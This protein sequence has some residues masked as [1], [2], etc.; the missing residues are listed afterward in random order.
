MCRSFQQ[1]SALSNCVEGRVA[2][3]IRLADR[4]V[5]LRLRRDAFLR[6]A[7]TQRTADATKA[8]LADSFRWMRDD[9]LMRKLCD[10][11]RLGDA[12]APEAA[13]KIKRA[14]E[15]GEVVVIPDTPRHSGVG[16]NG[17]NVLKPRPVTF[18]PSQLFRGTRRVSIA[19]SHVR[20]NPLRLSADDGLAI[21]AAR[22]GDVLPDG[23]IATAI[24]PASDCKQLNSD[25]VLERIKKTYEA[26]VNSVDHVMSLDDARPFG[27]ELSS[28][29]DNVLAM[30]A[31]GVSEAQEDD[32]F[33]QYERDMMACDMIGAMYRDPRTYA[34]CTR[35]AFSNYQG[36]RG[37]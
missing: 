26:S 30:A 2:D 22:P 10:L 21:W 6:S 19:G 4:S 27:L 20:P 15:T 34:E 12:D 13:F 32:C 1:T 33:S 36:C 3:E 35:R 16:S 18:T 5:T 11:L 14:F 29:S 8:F 23:T 25:D 24:L 7:D 37:Y 28:E 9:G 17:R 31:R